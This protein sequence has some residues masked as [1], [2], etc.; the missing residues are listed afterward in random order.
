MK[1]EN[2]VLEDT[3]WEEAK[4]MGRATKKR[5]EP[6]CNISVKQIWP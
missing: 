6:L 2:E 1:M 5:I 4:T 3:I